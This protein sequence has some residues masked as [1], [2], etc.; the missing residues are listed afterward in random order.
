VLNLL[1]VLSNRGLAQELRRSAADE[2]LV[3]AADPVLC[4]VMEQQQH[5]EALWTLCLPTE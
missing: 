1:A 2:L 3:L 4:V 5:L